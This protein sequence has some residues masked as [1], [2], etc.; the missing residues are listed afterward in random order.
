MYTVHD[1]ANEKG[2][3]EVIKSNF[4]PPTW[5]TIL[6]TE[7]FR[8]LF[9]LDHIWKKTQFNLYVETLKALHGKKH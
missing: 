8:A 2:R 5:N 3:Q 7:L 9:S 1:E 4:S 6:A